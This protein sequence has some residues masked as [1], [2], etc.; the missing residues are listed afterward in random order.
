VLAPSTLALDGGGELVVERW[1]RI[2]PG[3]RLTG[4]GRWNGRTVLA[5]LFVAA[6][7]AERHW[8]RECRGIDSLKQH[9]LPTAGLLASGRL[10][11]AGYYAITEYLEGAH[12]PDAASADA[13]D[14]VFETVGAMHARGIRQEDVHLDNFLIRPDGLYV[15]DGDAIRPGGSDR[16]RLDN[17]ALLFAQLPP[18]SS[19]AMQAALLAAYRKGN[20]SLAVDPV[21]LDAAIAR[22][23]EARLADYLGKCLRDCSLFKSARRADRFFSMAREEADF[24]APLVADPDAWLEQG[25][26]LKRG[27]SATLALVELEGRKLVIKLYNIK[28]VGHAL[29]RAW[30]PSRA[31]HSWIEAH[32][33]RFLGIA[34]PRPLALVER[35]LGP[36]RGRAWLVTEYCEGPILQECLEGKTERAA[37]D[38]V[39][40]AVRKLFAQLAAEHIG[41]GDL[42]ASNFILRGNELCVLD[43]DAMR[44]YDSEAAWRKAWRKDRARF[45]RNW[46]EGSALQREMDAALPPA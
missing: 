10:E 16:E 6:R 26:P 9:G 7:G 4:I 23:R 27:R 32:R 30:R 25:A 29:S 22:A 8:Q 24:L 12:S 5:K 39:Q 18:A 45:L 17:L 19:P 46:P 34:T 2:L 15:I 38:E 31:W 44:H 13:L 43:L 36:L 14:R 40:V 35:R 11:G 3:K 42:K 37:P 1:L 28:G 21:Q 33:L 41:H 20:P